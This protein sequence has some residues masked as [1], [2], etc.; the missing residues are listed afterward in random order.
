MSKKIYFY[1]KNHSKSKSLQW[2]IKIVN[3]YFLDYQIILTNKL[4]KNSAHI[5]MEG[6]HKNEFLHIK[7]NY[8]INNIK[9]IYLV[10]EFI[11]YKNKKF[12]TS[13]D[14]TSKRFNFFYY[15]IKFYQILKFNDNKIFKKF[16]SNSF[17]HI[18]KL[19][20]HF[21]SAKN[22]I[23]H[24]NRFLYSEKVLKMSSII[25]ST[26]PDIKKQLKNNFKKISYLLFP[27]L[28]YIQKKPNN[29]KKIKFS[30]LVTDY[31][32]KVLKRFGIKFNK[33]K[34]F[35]SIKDYNSNSKLGYKYS[36]HPKKSINWNYSSPI[37]YIYS[38][39][40]NEIPITINNFRDNFEKL[41]SL[42]DGKTFRHE[43]LSNDYFKNIKFINKK[44]NK[45]NK[46]IKKDYS[47]SN[48]EVK[49]LFKI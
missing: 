30:G 42:Y 20:L 3:Q 8:E 46:Y 25:F 37:R 12:I 11:D 5:I 13:E 26:H 45:Y 27:K 10:T 29:S 22:E 1:I 34:N 41:I 36:I 28:D 49:K 18:F 24:E 4:H 17:K 32:I 21:E 16:Y 48:L 9:I 7:K 19:F 23:R 43:N 44:I 15:L 31:R 35:I 6:F 14:T 38:I 2:Y 33:N 47:K 40:N 39:M